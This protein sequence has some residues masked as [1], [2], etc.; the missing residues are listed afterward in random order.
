MWKVDTLRW[1]WMLTLSLSLESILNPGLCGDNHP[2][3]TVINLL[4]GQ[5]NSCSAGDVDLRKK[6]DTEKE[7]SWVSWRL[8]ILTRSPVWRF[9]C[10]TNSQF[11]YLF[12]FS[13]FFRE[14]GKCCLMVGTGH[15]SQSRLACQPKKGE[16]RRKKKKRV[17][18]FRGIFTSEQKNSSWQETN[19]SFDQSDTP[20]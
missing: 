10:F 4:V 11:I 20:S 9:G 18:L 7:K 6:R 15:F 17:T 2:L 12:I 13:F 1:R 16:K 8:T 14:T 3:I 5:D 19:L